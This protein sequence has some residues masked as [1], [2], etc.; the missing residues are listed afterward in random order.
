ME[1]RERTVARGSDGSSGC[2]PALDVVRPVRVWVFA[3]CGQ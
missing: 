1:P 3:K 2:A